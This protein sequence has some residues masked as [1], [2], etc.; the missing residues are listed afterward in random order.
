MKGPEGKNALFLNAG[1]NFAGTIWYTL[2]KWRVVAEFVKLMEWDAMTLGNH[3]FDDGFT[4]LTPFMKAMNNNEV[5]NMSIVCANIET[6]GEPKRLIKPSIVVKRENTN[7]A[8]IGYI[9]PKTAYLSMTGK[10]VKFHDEI[11]SITNEIQRLKKK[12]GKSLNIFIALG[13]SG[14]DKDIEIAHSIP[15]LDVVVGG[16]SHTFLYSG[17]QLSTD[18]SEGTYPIVVD[19]NGQ[20]K[21]LVVQAF[22]AGKYLGKVDVSFDNNGIITSYGGAPILL[23]QSVQKGPDITSQSHEFNL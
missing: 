23:D 21:T 4:Q 18:I 1:D 3:E 19:H 17:K 20:G 16:H 10:S 12:Y 11:E 6:I 14:F 15:D 7:I 13:H 9:T 2:E 5:K 8:I 22:M